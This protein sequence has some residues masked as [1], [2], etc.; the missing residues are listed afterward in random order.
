MLRHSLVQASIQRALEKCCLTCPVLHSFRL[1]IHLI[2]TCRT[3]FLEGGR[4][5]KRADPLCVRVQRDMHIHRKI[6]L[7]AGQG[8]Q[9][10]DCLCLQCSAKD[11]SIGHVLGERTCTRGEVPLEGGQLES[12]G[13]V[14]RIT[15]SQAGDSSRYLIL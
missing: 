9:H 15:Q 11:P 2:H 12:S 8:R 14:G 6:M 7:W 13:V 4:K 3:A 10:V 5:E 1:E